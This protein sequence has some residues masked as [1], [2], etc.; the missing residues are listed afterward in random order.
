MNSVS[1][2]VR[3]TE[4]PSIALIVAISAHGG[5]RVAT[6]WCS[7]E[8]DLVRQRANNATGLARSHVSAFPEFPIQ[9]CHQE[10][11]II[12]LVFCRLYFIVL[13]NLK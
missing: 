8:P 4:R 2:A 12:S 9:P 13:N 7:E 5:S 10:V 3:N 11:R 1:K 6:G